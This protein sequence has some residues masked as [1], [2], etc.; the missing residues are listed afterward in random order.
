MMRIGVRSKA[1][2]DWCAPAVI[3]GI[4]LQLR[5]HQGNLIHN[6]L[7]MACQKV[8]VQEMEAQIKKQFK[9]IRMVGWGCW[10]SNI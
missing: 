6:H 5:L 10:G 7:E 2:Q 4:Y 9:M 1:N 3:G 8:V